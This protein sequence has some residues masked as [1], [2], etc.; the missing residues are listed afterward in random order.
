M[1]IKDFLV[2]KGDFAMDFCPGVNVFIGSNGTGKTTLLKALYAGTQMS[3]SDFIFGITEP[4]TIFVRGIWI[5][6]VRI[7]CYAH[8]QRANQTEYRALLG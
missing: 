8:S 3:S 4:D 2:F 1:E 5:P 6:K 7:T